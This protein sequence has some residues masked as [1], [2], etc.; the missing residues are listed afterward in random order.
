MDMILSTELTAKFPGGAIPIRNCDHSSPESPIQFGDFT[1]RPPA[2]PG[3][4]PAP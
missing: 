3:Q 2:E 4:N 1:I